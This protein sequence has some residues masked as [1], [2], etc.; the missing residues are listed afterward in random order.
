MTDTLNP[1]RP[2]ATAAHVVLAGREAPRLGFGAL[3]LAGPAGWGQPTDRDAAIALARGA[4]DAGIR[5]F[6]TADSLGSRRERESVLAEAPWPYP[7][8]RR[9]RD[10]G[11]DAA[12]RAA[13]SGACSGDQAQCRPPAGARVR[14]PACGVEAIPLFYLDRIDPGLPARGPARCAASTFATPA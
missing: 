14:A 3:H 7:D 12:H 4:L 11:R 13:S 8:A 2:A 9:D 6:D 1:T 10:E 5:Y